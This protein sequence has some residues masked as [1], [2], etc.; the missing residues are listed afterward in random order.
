MKKNKIMSPTF[1][2]IILGALI[3]ALGILKYFSSPVFFIFLGIVIFSAG[4]VRFVSLPLISVLVGVVIFNI[5]II[6]YVSYLEDRYHSMLT[7]TIKLAD[8]VATSFSSLESD[9]MIKQLM[10]RIYM[11]R[12]ENE[13]L[14]TQARKSERELNN[15]SQKEKSCQIRLNRILGQKKEVEE[16]TKQVRK[17]KQGKK[18]EKAKESIVGNKGFLL[19]IK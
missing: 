18:T 8:N 13:A 17:E 1:I 19:K 2:F 5:G 6:R 12:I 14:K 4:I 7:N 15:I 16:L 10:S 11:L 3:L 9:K